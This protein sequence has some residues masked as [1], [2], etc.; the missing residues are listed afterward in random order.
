MNKQLTF[1]MSELLGWK[2]DFEILPKFDMLSTE[3][4][5][6]KTR[7]ESERREYRTLTDM[8]AEQNFRKAELESRSLGTEKARWAAQVETTP[9]RNHGMFD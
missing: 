9:E 8:V 4:Q 7:L 5:D 2:H 3:S 6:L 1:L